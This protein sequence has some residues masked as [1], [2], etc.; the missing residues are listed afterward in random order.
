VAVDIACTSD[1]LRWIIVEAL[2]KAGIQR[3]GI[4]KDFI[5]ADDDLHKTP[6]VM[7]IY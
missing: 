2:K 4:R 5:H 1:S 7:W 6:K 3:I